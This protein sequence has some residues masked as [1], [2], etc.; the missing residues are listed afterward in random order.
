M[1]SSTFLK[2]QSGNT[3]YHCS[4]MPDQLLM[5]RNAAYSVYYT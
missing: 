1:K 4:C 2:Q 3:A 5:W